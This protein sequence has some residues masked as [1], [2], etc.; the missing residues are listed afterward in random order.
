MRIL[1]AVFVGAAIGFLWHKL[2]GGSCPANG[3]PIT[4]NPYV[5]SIFGAVMGAL[6]VA[7]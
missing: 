7:K 5:S 1:V 4:G 2:S 3:C 6:F